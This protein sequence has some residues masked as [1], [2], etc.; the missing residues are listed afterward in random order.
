MKK[1]IAVTVVILMLAFT[2]TGCAA[3]TVSTSNMPEQPAVQT[4]TPTPSQTPTPSPTPTQEP[5]LSPSPPPSPPTPIVI[6]FKDRI[7]E[8]VIRTI[9]NQPKGSITDQDMLKVWNFKFNYEELEAYGGRIK[10]LDDLRW[11][12]N[13]RRVILFD[14]KIKDISALSGTRDLV[15]FQ[16]QDKLKDF[17]PLLA[18]KKLSTIGLVGATD[19]FFRKLMENC[20]QLNVVSLHKSKI[21]SESLRMLAEKY[22]LSDLSLASCGITDI[23]PVAGLTG[24]QYLS[25]ER[26][27]IKD[28]SPLAKNPQLS[29]YI[30]LSANKITDWSPLENMT[31]LRFLSVRANP[32]TESP[33]LDK[34]EKNGCKIYR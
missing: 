2:A 8:K 19:D 31:A 18:N 11:C 13:L 15:E 34:L 33:A 22:K 1:P 6:K 7:V 29:R 21:S 9:L 20:D 10:T 4:E 30:D 17:T 26:N 3:Q 14:T 27:K 23:S 16:C 12:V 28:I 25:L 5:T 32:V 24:L